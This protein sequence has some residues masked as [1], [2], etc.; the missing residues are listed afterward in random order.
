MALLSLILSS[1]CSDPA[2]V[3]IELTPGNN[4]I[5]VSFVDFELPAEV[6]LLDS[7]N[8]TNQSVLVIGEEVD[9]Y[10]GKT[11]GT[12]FSRVYIDQADD[13][14]GLNAILDSIF[15]KLDV[16]S[17]NGQNLEEPKFYSIHKLTEPLLDTLYYNFN[18]LAYEEAPFSSSEV[19]FGET[20]D[21]TLTFLVEEAFAEEIF[22]KMKRGNEFDDL[23]KFREYFPGIAVK[24]REGDNTTIGVNL[25]FN[26]GIFTYYHNEG[27]TVSTL[28]EITT[29][30]SRSF[31]GVVSDR[32]GTPTS[33]VTER[34]KSYSTGEFVGLKSNLG[35]TIKIDTSPFDAF[36]DTLSGVTFNNAT[37]EIGEINEVPEGQNPPAFFVMYFTDD[38]NQILYR[39]SD[40][41]PMTVQRDGQPQTEIVN[42]DGAKEPV[43]RAPAIASFDSESKK[44]IVPIT[45]HVNALFRNE[46][47]RKDWLLYA[48]TPDLPGDDFKKSLK[49]MV[50]NKGKIK[51]RVIYS[52]TS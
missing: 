6:V 18:S 44:Y 21:T 51:V 31:N 36:L 9:S 8:T 7:F 43:I 2:R 24:A 40:N 17:V 28:Y 42:E 25:G 37:F 19:E 45:S 29:A 52:K 26:T 13:R 49:Q 3:G 15:F 34:S 27:D 5:G 32:S 22:G 33:V 4:Q 16:V 38:T 14:P 46:L 10:F 12:G 41:Q 30:S 11:S 50:V 1:S 23:F 39:S 35:L 20:K 47:L 48:N